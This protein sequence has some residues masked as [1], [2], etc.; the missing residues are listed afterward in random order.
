MYIT[1]RKLAPGSKSDMIR[2]YPRRSFSFRRHPDWLILR[3]VA[4]G[5]GA[6]SR[7]TNKLLGRHVNT[8][9][10]LSR[11][12]SSCI[13]FRHPIRTSVYTHECAR[14]RREEKQ[15][16]RER[17]RTHVRYIRVLAENARCDPRVHP[18]ASFNANFPMQNPV[19]RGHPVCKP[20]PLHVVPTTII[21][22]I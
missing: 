15:R 7:G 16:E 4:A 17:P 12:K 11:A 3:I 13:I 19:S 5:G 10:R 8:R 20:G 21:R 6:R 9:R 14:E 22:H 18:R 2:I 1:S